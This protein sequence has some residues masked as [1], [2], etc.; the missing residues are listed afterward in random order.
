MKNSSVVAT[1]TAIEE[2]AVIG[3]SPSEAWDTIMN[4]CAIFPSVLIYRDRDKMAAILQ[5][6]SQMYFL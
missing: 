1:E 6:T 5:T 4:V 3:T 2:Q